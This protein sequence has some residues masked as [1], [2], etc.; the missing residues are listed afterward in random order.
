MALS[1]HH[2]PLSFSSLILPRWEIK[3]LKTSTP[4][5]VNGIDT[6]TLHGYTHLIADSSGSFLGISDIDEVLRYLTQTR[7]RSAHNFF[8]N[9]AYDLDSIVKYLDSDLLTDLINTGKVTYQDYTLSYIPKKLFS[10]GHKKH[11]YSYYD[12]WQFFE[13]SLEI[14]AMRYL[15]EQKNPEGLDRARLGTSPGY[16]KRHIRAIERYCVSDAELTQRLGEMLQREVMM[17]VSL[18]PRRYISKAG[19]SKQYFRN[20]CQIPDIRKVPINALEYFYHAY[21]GGR[22]EVTARGYCGE[23]SGID[24]NSAYP[25]IIADLI[26]ITNG[27]WRKVTKMS[28]EAYYG[29]YVATIDLP[30]M[31]LPPCAMRAGNTTLYPSGKWTGYFLKEELVEVQKLGTIDIHVGWEFYPSEI[32]YPF[33]ASIYNLY[34]HKNKAVKDSYQYDLYKKVMNSLYGSFYEKVRYPDGTVKAGLFFN[35][36]YAS[37]ITGKTRLQ[38]WKEAQKYGNKVVSLATDG[39]VLSGPVRCEPSKELGAFSPKEHG[40][41]IILRSGIYEIG[42]EMKS[43]GVSKLGALN[44]PYG[45]YPSIFAY[46]RAH[47]DLME[48]PVLL[49]RPVHLKEAIKHHKRFTKEDINLFMDLEYIV[50]LN[51]EIKRR[52]T[53]KDITGDDILHKRFNSIVWNASDITSLSGKGE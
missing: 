2:N 3:P 49:H 19:L 31:F 4:K 43:R 33:R 51:S 13:S 22:F 5:P 18:C 1:I 48:Y 15:G 52:Y 47:P 23:C 26:D 21:H 32:V 39:I 20:T 6:E 9:I 45:Q 35:P 41:C 29:A 40:E 38:L 46:L 34:T 25:A 42:T 24:I 14:A 17:A 27:K 10:I 7:F 11:R 28:A 50:D 44:T 12:L 37:I 36:V 30:F 16:W 53:R 8:W